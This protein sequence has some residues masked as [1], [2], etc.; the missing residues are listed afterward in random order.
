MANCNESVP[1]TVRPAPPSPVMKSPAVPV[2]RLIAV[3]LTTC[4][5]ALVSTLIR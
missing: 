2:S 1:L 3:M 5:G 4:N